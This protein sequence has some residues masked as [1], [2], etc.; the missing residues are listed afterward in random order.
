MFTKNVFFDC[1]SAVLWYVPTPLSFSC[2]VVSLTFAFSSFLFTKNVFSLTLSQLFYGMFLLSA[3]C[4][5][6]YRLISRNV[7][8]LTFSQLFY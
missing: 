5:D 7:D 2:H 6:Y 1:F 8:L 4:L 3:Q